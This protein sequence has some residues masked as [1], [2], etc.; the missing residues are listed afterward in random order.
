V[1]AAS[2]TA[3]AGET[4]EVTLPEDYADRIMLSR[5][6]LRLTLAEF[7]ARIGAAN[8]AVVYQWESGKR[9]PSPVFSSRIIALRPAHGR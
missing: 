6:G 2:D 8:K 7:A 1:I 3:E 9:K 4:C 5:H